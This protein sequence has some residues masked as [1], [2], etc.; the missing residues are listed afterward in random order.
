MFGNSH[1]RGIDLP[2]RWVRK[3]KLERKPNEESFVKSRLGEGP[4]TMFL[5]LFQET[6][7]HGGSTVN[8]ISLCDALEWRWWK[9]FFGEKDIE[10]N[11][12]PPPTMSERCWTY[13]VI[14]RQGHVWPVRGGS[15]RFESNICVVN[16]H[17]KK[18][19][20]G[21]NPRLLPGKSIAGIPCARAD[22]TQA[23]V[24]AP[25]LDQVCCESSPVKQRCPWE[26][27]QK[28]W[29]LRFATF[30]FWCWKRRNFDKCEVWG[31]FD[32]IWKALWQM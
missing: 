22:D 11:Y 15:Y 25:L 8:S 10:K 31:W 14:G 13:M 20:D 28:K 26:P 27:F 4:H 3:N 32:A 30:W 12:L 5:R 29:K 21:R 23:R 19:M 7:S 16:Q 18:Q 9:Y 24:G 17:V 2:P 1:F 6:W